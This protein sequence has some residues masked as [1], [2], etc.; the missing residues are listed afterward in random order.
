MYSVPRRRGKKRDTSPSAGKRRKY[1]LKRY[2]KRHKKMKKEAMKAERCRANTWNP[3][4][5]MLIKQKV[6]NLFGTRWECERYCREHAASIGVKNCVNIYQNA[7]RWLCRAVLSNMSPT[8]HSIDN[9]ALESGNLLS[10]IRMQMDVPGRRKVATTAQGERQKDA[11]MR[12]HQSK[13]RDW[14]PTN[15]VRISCWKA[16]KSV[17]LSKKKMCIQEIPKHATFAA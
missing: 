2:R 15:L 13:F 10:L 12:T 5:E 16:A 17:L 6:E 1:V 11:S 9:L 7:V 14:S 3:G 8:Q 4:R